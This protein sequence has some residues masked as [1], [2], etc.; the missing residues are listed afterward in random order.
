[1]S[2]KLAIGGLAVGLS[3]FGFASSA[4][5]FRYTTC[6]DEKVV[7]D[8]SIDL[9]RNT[10]SIPNGS[11]RHDA[12][13]NA[14]SRWNAVVGMAN[15][16]QLAGT[17]SGSVIT[18]GDDQNDVAVVNRSSIDG[19]NG[20]TLVYIGG[21]WAW[22]AD[23]DETDVLVA[24]DLPFANPD[25]VSLSTT[26][27]NTFIHEFGHAI[28]L[29]HHDKANLL[30]TTQPRP[31]TGGAAEHVDV[32]PDDAQG[33]R[34]LYP[35]GLSQKN[36]FATAQRLEGGQITNENGFTPQFGCPGGLVTVK[37]TVGNNGT[38]AIV[39]NQRFSMSTS[40]TGY[41]G[42]TTMGVWSGA[43]NN[44]NGYFSGSVQLT[45]P[46]VAPGIYFLF[47]RVDKD[48]TTTESRESDNVVRLNKTLQILDCN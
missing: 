8:G 45:I 28:G 41:T 35:T 31:K 3:L 23:I 48:G 9:V 12:F 6:S 14:V 1:M 19:N 7:W 24:S 10:F 37:F 4:L 29:L 16:F 17:T 30:R 21:C 39:N 33:G 46:N 25:E 20:L 11:T 27:R 18:N 13:T 38:D 40:K 2:M 22:G 43:T 34:F 32:L 42:G 15:E 47:Y 44:P 5:A 36:L 26:G